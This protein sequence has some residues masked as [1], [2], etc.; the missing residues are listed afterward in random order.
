[1][2]RLEVSAGIG[3]EAKMG[4]T[5]NTHSAVERPGVYFC[6]NCNDAEETLH[7][8]DQGPVCVI[9]KR[10]VTWEWRR[11]LLR[12]IGFRASP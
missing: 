3:T 6:T 9:C 5:V 7:A 8:G 12:G 4:P 10:P 1:M 2:S 11:P